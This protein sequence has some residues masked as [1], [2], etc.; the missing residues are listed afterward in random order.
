MLYINSAGFIISTIS[1]PPD[2]ILYNWVFEN[3]ILADEQFVK[4]L[5]IFESCVWV[6]EN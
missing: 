4:A 1:N 5:Q 6:Y 3:S 2:C